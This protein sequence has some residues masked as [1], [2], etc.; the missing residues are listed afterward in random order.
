LYAGQRAIVHQP[1]S[2]N[3]V[4]KHFKYAWWKRCVVRLN[5]QVG[6]GGEFLQ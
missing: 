5:D 6:S 4:G 2:A 3:H 1:V